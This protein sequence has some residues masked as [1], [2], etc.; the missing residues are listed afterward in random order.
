MPKIMGK[1]QIFDCFYL[2]FLQCGKAFFC[3]QN[4]LEHIFLAY[5]AYEKISR[6]KNCQFLTKTVDFPLFQLAIFIV[7]K[8][9]FFLCRTSLN[10]FF[11]AY[12]A[13]NIKIKTLPVF[14]QNHGLF[15]KN[16]KFST[17]LT[18][19]FYSLERVFSFLEYIQT[20]FDQLFFLYL[21]LK[22][23]KNCQF[24]TKAMD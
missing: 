18:C 7:W 3:S 10:T 8:G 23:W 12:F 2:L 5:F 21:Q 19:C 24:L 20:H 11:L 9:F 4:I 22:I 13:H 17:I 16:L 15:W 1:S 6:L 14:D